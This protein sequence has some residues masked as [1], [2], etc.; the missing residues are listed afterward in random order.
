MVTT[1]NLNLSPEALAALAQKANRSDN[2]LARSLG[3]S[4]DEIVDAQLP[5]T[6]ANNK[7]I[8]E[9]NP[10]FDPTKFGQALA[11]NARVDAGG[12]ITEEEINKSENEKDGENDLLDIIQNNL[13]R[14]EAE[15]VQRAE[16][17]MNEDH[18]YAGQKMSASEWLATIEWF[19]DDENIANWEAEMQNR[20]IPSSRM[21]SI[22]A[23]MDRLDELILKESRGE[24]LTTDEKREMETLGNDNEVKTGYGVRNDLVNLYNNVTNDANKNLGVD[25]IA[26]GTSALEVSELDTPNAIIIGNQTEQAITG[27]AKVEPVST[28]LSKSVDGSNQS[29]GLTSSFNQQANAIASEQLNS[30]PQINNN[31]I[32]VRVAANFDASTGMI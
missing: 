6:D 5:D 18:T 21:R 17:W 4:M 27:G 7:Q 26:N 16:Q 23:R 8:F 10:F 14:E 31:Q 11:A 1:G 3:I 32:N 9:S 25:S 20:G 19:Q 13:A 29:S 30:A 24:L 22:R 2:E 28:S 15:R 12:Y